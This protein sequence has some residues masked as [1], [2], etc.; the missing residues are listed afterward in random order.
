V[1]LTEEF[2]R[3]LCQNAGFTL[4]VN[5]PYGN[6]AH[7]MTEAIFKG[8]ARVMFHAMT[9]SARQVGIPSTKGVI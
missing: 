7:H 8:L 4:H 2:L 6:N 9:I 1:Q 5:V 3:A